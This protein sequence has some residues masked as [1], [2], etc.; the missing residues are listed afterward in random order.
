MSTSIEAIISLIKINNTSKNHFNDNELFSE[1]CFKILSEC[2][3]S[4]HKKRFATS[5]KL[6]EGMDKFLLACQDKLAE[7]KKDIFIDDD[8]R[9]F[10]FI[11][12]RILDDNVE[13]LSAWNTS[14]QLFDD[15]F[16]WIC[17]SDDKLKAEIKE[18]FWNSKEILQAKKGLKIA[19]F[20]GVGG[21]E[22]KPLLKKL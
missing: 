13:E 8:Q 7:V 6:F 12:S 3:S 16:N 1:S 4:Y 20:K 15:F 17:S 11:P 19:E 2:Y 9:L 5:E 18:Q 21:E 10:D 22:A 14:Y